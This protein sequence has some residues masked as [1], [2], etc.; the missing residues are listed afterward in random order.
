MQDMSIQTTEINRLKEQVKN[1]ED[2]NKL[3]QVMYKS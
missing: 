1:L 3:S 2:E